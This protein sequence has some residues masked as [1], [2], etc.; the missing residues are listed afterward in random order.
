[1]VVLV[2]VSQEIKVL[3]IVFL[4]CFLDLNLTIHYIKRERRLELGQVL[5]EK[6]DVVDVFVLLKSFCIDSG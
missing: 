1:M 2:K 6:F 3:L 4:R 5:S